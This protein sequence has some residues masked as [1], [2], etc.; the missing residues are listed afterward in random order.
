MRKVA[1]WP[2][3]YADERGLAWIEVES[4][5]NER[6]I[7]DAVYAAFGATAIISHI[8]DVAPPEPPRTEAERAWARAYA[9]EMTKGDNT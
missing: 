2:K 7:K 1:I 3:G 9:R 4:T 5:A 6:A 8:V